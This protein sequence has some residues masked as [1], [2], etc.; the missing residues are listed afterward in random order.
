MN[1]SKEL[2]R[3]SLTLL[4]FGTLFGCSKQSTV[5]AGIP[6]LPG[7]TVVKAETNSQLDLEGTYFYARFD[8]PDPPNKAVVTYGKAMLAADAKGFEL[9]GPLQLTENERN[10]NRKRLCDF[11]RKHTINK[12][13]YHQGWKVVLAN[14]PSYHAIYAYPS[15]HGSIVELISYSA[16]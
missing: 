3:L 14:E 7:W 10:Q 8:S 2:V 16:L 1:P 6:V 13:K 5:P 12:T 9:E 15:D 4:L 11:E